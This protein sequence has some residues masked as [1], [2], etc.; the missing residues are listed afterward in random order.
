MT[1]PK[2]CSSARRPPF[3]LRVHE[4]TGLR[5]GPGAPEE[6]RQAA[7]VQ[8]DGPLARA[9]VAFAHCRD[10]ARHDPVRQRSRPPTTAA[11]NCPPRMS[12][13]MPCSSRRKSRRKA[14]GT[15]RI[16]WGA[17]DVPGTAGGPPDHRGP[18]QQGDRRRTGDR[19]ANRSN[20]HRRHQCVTQPSA[21]PVFP[22]PPPGQTPRPASLLL[23]GAASRTVP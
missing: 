8:E 17:A 1:L 13:P 6:T 7:V 19:A 12:S 15:G 16:R 3:R 11:W 5:Q 20:R 22:A 2:G 10:E 9:H 18:Q 4:R 23:V 21:D 14:A